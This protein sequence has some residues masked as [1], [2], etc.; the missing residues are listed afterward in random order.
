MESRRLSCGAW[1]R[2]G[3]VRWE[4]EVLG[5]RKKH[6]VEEKRGWCEL[7]VDDRGV[8]EQRGRGGGRGGLAISHGLRT[9][10]IVLDRLYSFIL[11]QFHII[12]RGEQGPQSHA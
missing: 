2:G 12:R 9:C 3:M 1:G 6:A 5:Q 10:T 8:E 7:G 11:V 4:T